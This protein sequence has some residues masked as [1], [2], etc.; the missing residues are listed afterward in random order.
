MSGGLENSNRSK[1][2][3][4]VAPPMPEKQGEAVKADA[5]NKIKGIKSDVEISITKP[6]VSKN[7]LSGLKMPSWV[8]P[9]TQAKIDEIDK[10]LAANPKSRG[11]LADAI[12]F[13]TMFSGLFAGF[14]NKF[15]ARDFIKNLD[16]EDRYVDIEPSEDEKK[17]LRTGVLEESPQFKISGS[18]EVDSTRHACAVLGINSVDD[19]RAMAAKLKHSVAIG[20]EENKPFYS[21][22]MSWD[23][24]RNL[25]NGI[26]V[27]TVLVASIFDRTDIKSLVE[28]SYQQ[29]FVMTKDGLR[30]IDPKTG[31]SKIF[32][33]DSDDFPITS[34]MFSLAA[35]F[36]PNFTGKDEEDGDKDAPSKDPEVIKK[37]EQFGDDLRE[38]MKKN[39]KHLEFMKKDSGKNLEKVDKMFEELEKDIIKD[40]VKMKKQYPAIKKALPEKLKIVL[41]QMLEDIK[42]DAE[43]VL[44]K[45]LRDPEEDRQIIIAAKSLLRVSKEFLKE[46]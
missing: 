30:G 38:I 18:M 17:V 33:L 10:R 23:K 35:S 44:P 45:L 41:R 11:P 15:I 21:T 39:E 7:P 32:A 8:D 20:K 19:P 3:T 36:V 31:K 4:K 26:P 2:I 16:E 5:A 1:K 13:F 34:G 14:K 46:L 6:Q 37:V 9:S 22:G 42:E 28:K 12:K 43:E 24:L 25:E 40:L 27:G 29:V